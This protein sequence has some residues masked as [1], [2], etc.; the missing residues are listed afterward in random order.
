MTDMTIAN[1]R[2]G[3]E[4]RLEVLEKNLQM[5]RDELRTYQI[6]E[7]SLQAHMGHTLEMILSTRREMTSIDKKLKDL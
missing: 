3:A 4:R 2:R 6:T 5:F 7:R 1:M